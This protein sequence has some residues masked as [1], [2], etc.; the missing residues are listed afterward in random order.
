MAE[1]AAAE[2]PMPVTVGQFVTL[3]S[4]DG[5]EFI[6]SRKAALESGTIKNM[7]SGPATYDE[8]EQNE[9]AFR[10]IPSHVLERVCTYFYYKMR[11]TNSNQEIP[12]F[13]IRPEEALD[14]LMAANFLRA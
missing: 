7:L 9:V 14:L 10:E 3:V 11:Y 8:D 2:D 1:G 13:A 5:F 6:V 4:K 12:E